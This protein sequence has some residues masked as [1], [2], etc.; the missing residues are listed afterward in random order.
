MKSDLGV[1]E[2]DQQT[3]ENFQPIKT[4]NYN[5][6][7]Y[8]KPEIL[9]QDK[10][11]SNLLTC[12]KKFVIPSSTLSNNNSATTLKRSLNIKGDI[13]KKNKSN[14]A[15]RDELIPS[16]ILIENKHLN[17]KPFKSVQS[18]NFESNNNVSYQYTNDIKSNAFVPSIDNRLRKLM[19]LHQINA[20]E[21]ILEKFQGINVTI[22]DN[23]ND[24]EPSCKDDLSFLDNIHATIEDIDLF[25]DDED[26]DYINRSYSQTTYSNVNGAILADEMGLGKT[27]VAI[28]VIWAYIGSIRRF[29]VG[30]SPKAIVVCPSSLINNWEK[31]YHTTINEIRK[32]EIIVCDEGHRLKNIGG[33]KTIAA[34]NHSSADKRLI[35]SGTP[36]QNDLDELFAIVSFVKPGLLGDKLSFQSNFSAP[37]SK[38]NDMNSTDYDR[39]LNEVALLAQRRGWEYM[40]LDGSLATDKRQ[41]LVDA[42]NRPSD[43][44]R[45]F[46]LSS[47]AG[48]VG[49]NL[50]GGSRLVMMDC[51]WN[52]ATDSQAMSRIWRDGQTKPVHIYRLIS[53]DVI[54][55][56]ILMRQRSKTALASL[57]NDESIESFKSNEKM[58][59]TTTDVINLIQ[60]KFQSSI[61]IKSINKENILNDET[62]EN[63]SVSSNYEY[64]N[65]LLELSSDPIVKVLERLKSIQIVHNFEVNSKK[66]SDTVNE[67]INKTK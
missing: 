57:I 63:E 54:E 29:Q 41:L 64:L 9:P 34:L 31:E 28:S 42:F 8:K 6:T 2:D 39:R 5:S 11:V 44:R 56:A 46:L 27:L 58:S 66:R 55:D 22:P 37:I 30:A 12:A 33:T 65:P 59:L 36:I 14:N 67:I 15:E 62:I 13:N 4:F 7:S 26:F 1:T 48:G 52:P 40:R 21:W 35:L 20:A 61:N 43:H 18:D 38:G 32:V 49:I 60:P 45:I 23:N 47:K 17:L 24:D 19:R 50:I 16:N 53:Q 10:A 3:F 25:S 51:D